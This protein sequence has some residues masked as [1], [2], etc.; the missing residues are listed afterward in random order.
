M[1][2]KGDH[3]TPTKKRFPCV[4]D[5]VLL[6]N[7]KGLSAAISS[8]HKLQATKQ[9][10]NRSA[11]KHRPYSSAIK[12]RK[13]TPAKFYKSPIRIKLALD[14]FCSVAKVQLTDSMEH[15]YKITTWSDWVTVAIYLGLGLVG[16]SG[17]ITLVSG[18]ASQCCNM[19]ADATWLSCLNELDAAT[20]LSL[21]LMATVWVLSYTTTIAF[22]SRARLRR[23]KSGTEGLSPGSRIMKTFFAVAWA[24]AR[25]IP[26]LMWTLGGFFLY[27]TK[28]WMI[29]PILRLW[30]QSAGP[31]ADIRWDLDQLVA[32]T[33]NRLVISDPMLNSG[34]H[35][36]D[37]RV[38]KANTL[39]S[40]IRQ[41][42][43]NRRR[44]M[45]VSQQTMDRF[46]NLN[47]RIDLLFDVRYWWLAF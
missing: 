40:E 7:Q 42:A 8:C 17:D 39:M 1:L 29:G 4:Q 26:I 22:L 23:H 21:C 46:F 43:G 25:V 20:L 30:L 3:H 15:R 10:L 35:A 34:Y 5:R 13:R 14:N 11:I 37:H 12:V 38:A 16:L 19:W 28:V 36:K 6:F 31:L 45:A 24:L 27:I 9:V 41:A 47:A 2:G 18:L 33:A 44:R 32:T